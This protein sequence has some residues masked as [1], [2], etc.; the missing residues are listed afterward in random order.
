MTPTPADI[1]GKHEGDLVL[2]LQARG[3]SGCI[4]QGRGRGQVRARLVR[5]ALMEK[6]A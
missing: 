3:S 1:G 5:R 2:C 6:S 4:N